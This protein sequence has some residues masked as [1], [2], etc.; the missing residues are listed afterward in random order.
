[1]DQNQQHKSTDMP[2]CTTFNYGTL[3]ILSSEKAQDIL[4]GRGFR[5]RPHLLS[6][7]FVS[8]FSLT[9]GHDGFPSG[10][11]H[12]VAITAGARCGLVQSIA[13]LD[14]DYVAPDLHAARS[15]RSVV[16]S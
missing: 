15:N 4:K 16:W 3:P 1:M 8:I 2:Q 11:H 12:L 13:R 6:F 9:S 10:F 14:R 7:L 5:R